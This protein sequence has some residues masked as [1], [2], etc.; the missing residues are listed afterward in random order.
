[1]NG[2]SANIQS[3]FSNADRGLKTRQKPLSDDGG[4]Y[5]KHDL[6]ENAYIDSAAEQLINNCAYFILQ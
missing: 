2:Q 5:F 4:I 3:P 6:D 1:M